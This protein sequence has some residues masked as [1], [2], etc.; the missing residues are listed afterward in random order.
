MQV[1]GT[2]IAWAQYH[3]GATSNQRAARETVKISSA[4]SKNAREFW[5]QSTLS[6]ED[7]QLAKTA[8]GIAPDCIM[9]G[10][11]SRVQTDA[12]RRRREVGVEQSMKI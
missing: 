1:S 10:M 12:E 9:P 5:Q 3:R 4:Q 8:N 11:P 6:S 7:G 2:G